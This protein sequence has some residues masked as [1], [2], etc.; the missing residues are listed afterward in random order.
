MNKVTKVLGISFITNAFLSFIK[1]LV[2]LLSQYSSLI[3][4]GIHS[5]SDLSTD[6]IAIFGNHMCMKPEDDKHP[7]GHGKIEYVTSLIIGLIIVVLG[8]LLIYNSFNASIIIPN[9]FVALVSLFTIIAKFILA[10]YINR[11]GKKYSNYILI[12]SSNESQAD[13]YSS[14]FV[15]IS[16]VLMH[17]SDKVLIFKYANLIGTIIVSILIIRTGYIILKENVSILLEEQVTDK[18]YIGAI[19]ELILSFD[20]VT[21]LENLYILRYGSYYKLMAN[22]KMK[23]N[24]TLNL[25]HSITDEIEIEI[26]KLDDKIKYVFIHMEP[27]Q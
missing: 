16:V 20:E 5:L 11:K 6:V 9:T 7:F 27:E 3:A 1:I 23:D 4:D 13:V 21:K 26:K 22:I 19:K 8:C 12:A 24:I 25:A 17:F 14:I 2:G 15:L 18:K 10:K